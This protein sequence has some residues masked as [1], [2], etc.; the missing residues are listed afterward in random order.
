M[1]GTFL[2]A[3]D[4]SSAELTPGVPV[5]FGFILKGKTNATAYSVDLGL[6]TSG[7]QPTTR[8]ISFINIPVSD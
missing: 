7:P 2:G 6:S 4:N 5:Q 1:A 8:Q 3:A